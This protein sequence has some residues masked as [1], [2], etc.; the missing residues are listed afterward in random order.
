MLLLLSCALVLSM[1]GRTFLS[2]NDETRTQFWLFWQSS[3]LIYSQSRLYF[4]RPWLCDP[5]T[6][7]PTN[8]PP[9]NPTSSLHTYHTDLHTPRGGGRGGTRVFSRLNSRLQF[10]EGKFRKSRFRDSR[11]LSSRLITFQKQRLKFDF[12]CCSTLHRP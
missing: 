12:R 7:P 1:Y 11:S 3:S 5:I 6:C 10:Q 9:L 8:P 4:L 2:Q